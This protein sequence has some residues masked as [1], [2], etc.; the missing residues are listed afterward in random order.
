MNLYDLFVENVFGGFWTSVTGFVFIFLIILA[1]GAVSS[2]SIGFFMMMFLLAMA[3]GY[4]NSLISVPIAMGIFA[5]TLYQFYAWM[6][7]G[8]SG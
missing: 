8:G 6:E 3:I 5:W 2:Y 1:V 4:G 7:R